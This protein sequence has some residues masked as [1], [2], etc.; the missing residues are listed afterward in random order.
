MR[1]VVLGAGAI[2]GVIGARLA[3]AGQKV[4]LIARGEHAAVI[5]RDGLTIESPG[6]AETLRLQVATDPAELGIAAD[7][8]V[9]LAV[10]SQHTVPALESLRAAAPADTPVVCAQ[11]GVANEREA[12]RRFERVLALCVMC[13]AGYLEPGV[14][15]AWS[16]PVTGLLDVG[17]FPESSPATWDLAREVSEALR[18]ATFDSLVRTDIMRWKYAKLVMNLG[19][20]VQA[21]CGPQAPAG[22]LIQ[23]LRAEAYGCFDA[24]GIDVA[25][26]EEDRQRRGDLLAI[27][28]VGEQPWPGGSS[29]QSL[30]RAAGS[31]ETDHLNGEITLLGR[32]HGVPTP[33][34]ALVQGLAAESLASG[35]KPGTLTPEQIL[36]MLGR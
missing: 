22:D 14:V 12:L 33:A 25:S 7:D 36:A 35:A 11:N 10:K 15:K 5:G 34:N 4:A 6:G 2:G 21:L 1:F 24:A 26:A 23:I 17:P 13:P 28:P 16:D 30:A 8:V 3:Q 27:Q 32:L 9:L 29:W 31:I 19:N 18:A 20:V